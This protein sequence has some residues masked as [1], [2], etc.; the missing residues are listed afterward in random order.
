MRVSLDKKSKDYHS[1]AYSMRCFLNGK[2]VSSSMLM[3]DEELGEV[4]LV[5]PGTA[6]E[7]CEVFK[8]KVELKCR[9]CRKHPSPGVGCNMGN[10]HRTP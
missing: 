6:I 8:G 5:A 10:H 3:A 1:G 2:E 9:W 7:D 4:G